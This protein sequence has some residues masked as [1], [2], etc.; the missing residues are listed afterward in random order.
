MQSKMAG[1]IKLSLSTAPQFCQ[2]HKNRK[3]NVNP[4]CGI[5]AKGCGWERSIKSPHVI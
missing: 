5:L 3:L 1:V 2:V 4:A